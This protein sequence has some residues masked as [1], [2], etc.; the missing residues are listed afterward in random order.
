[1]LILK[2]ISRPK[3]RLLE[4]DSHKRFGSHALLYFLQAAVL[5]YANIEIVSTPFCNMVYNSVNKKVD[6]KLF[7]CLDDY[8]SPHKKLVNGNL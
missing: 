7:I 5:Q 1:M 4:W 3:R 6:S 8:T 2:I